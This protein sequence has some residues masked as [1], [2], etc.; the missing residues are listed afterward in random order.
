MLGK[1]GEKE[2]Q[3]ERNPTRFAKSSLILLPRVVAC[4]YLLLPF[5]HLLSAILPVFLHNL[6]LVPST[7]FCFIFYLPLT[8]FWLF[9]VAERAWKGDPA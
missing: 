6:A 4:F 5:L 3:K 1:Q 9:G 8:I 7:P 2:D